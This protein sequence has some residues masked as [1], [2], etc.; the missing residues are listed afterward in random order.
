MF[1]NRDDQNLVLVSSLADSVTDTSITKVLR[2]DAHLAQGI[3]LQVKYYHQSSNGGG[4]RFSL[5]TTKPSYPMGILRDTSLW[6][7]TSRSKTRS[8]EENIVTV[9]T[10]VWIAVHHRME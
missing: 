3:L 4:G 1:R 5:G 9:Q 8:V 7:N 6:P 2:L 10:P